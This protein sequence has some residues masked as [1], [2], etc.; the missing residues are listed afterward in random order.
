LKNEKLAIGRNRK[1]EIFAMLISQFACLPQAGIDVLMTRGE[2]VHE[3][4]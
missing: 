4:D 2:R 1:I 3:I